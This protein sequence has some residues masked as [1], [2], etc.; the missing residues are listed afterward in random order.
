MAS[1]VQLGFLERR[2]AEVEEDVTSLYSEFC[3]INEFLQYKFGEI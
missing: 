3:L 1:T 2:L